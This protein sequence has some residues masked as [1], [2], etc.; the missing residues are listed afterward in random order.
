MRR[1][2]F[3][4]IIIRSVGFIGHVWF[5][6]VVTLS[7]LFVFDRS[8]SVC[9]QPSIWFWLV[10]V[11]VLPLTLFRISYILVLIGGLFIKFLF[12]VDKSSKL[13]VVDDWILKD[14]G[15][16]PFYFL[17]LNLNFWFIIIFPLDLG[18]CVSVDCFFILFLR[19]LCKCHGF[20]TSDE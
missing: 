17:F 14:F 9:W 10:S 15:I 20:V 1:F 11:N 13:W 6:S 19:A 12:F 8:Y 3:I 7:N 16:F 18:Q 4:I 2:V 5:L